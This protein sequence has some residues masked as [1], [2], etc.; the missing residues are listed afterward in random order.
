MLRQCQTCLQLPERLLEK[1][2]NDHKS[3]YPLTLDN[4]LRVVVVHNPLTDRSAAAIAVNVGHFNDPKDRQGLAHFLEHMLFLGTEKYPDGSEYN[5]FISQHGGNNNA[6]TGTEHTSFFFDIDSQQFEPALDRFSSFFICPLLSKEFV[7]SERQNIDAEFKLKLKDDI[8]R[9]YDVHKETINQKHPFSQFSVGNI[10]T[11]EDRDNS[12]IRDEVAAF[13]ENYYRAQHMTLVL[14]GPQ[15]IEQ[16]TE[17]AKQYFGAIKS[18]TKTLPKITEPLY[19]ADNLGIQIDVK[20]EKQ[21][22]NLIISFAMPALDPHYRSKPLS[23]ISYLL[24]HEGHGS[25]LSELKRKQWAMSLTAGGGINASNFKDFNISLQLTESGLKHQHDIVSLVFSYINL[26]KSEGFNEVYYKE[27]QTLYSHAFT[28]Q[29]KLSSID[30]AKQLVLNMQHYPVH[31]YIFGDYVMAG[32]DQALYNHFMAYLDATNMRLISIHKDIVPSKVSHWYQV[33]YHVEK[34]DDNQLSAWQQSPLLD[35]FALPPV[36][37]Y[38]ISDPQVL[39]LEPQP[40]KPQVIVDNSGFRVWHRQDTSFGVPKGNI[41]I[42][43]DSPESVSSLKNMAMTKLFV[44][45]FSDSVIEENYNAEIAGI[46]YHMF[47][48][49]AGFSLQISGFSQKQPDLLLSLSHGLHRHQFD[50]PRFELFR[51]QLVQHLKNSSKSKSI[52]QLFSWLSSLMQ[53]N[54]PLTA[55]VIDALEAIDFET[56]CR[57]CEQVFSSIAI[58]VFIYGNWPKSHALK[59]A[60]VIEKTF[61]GRLSEDAWVNCPVTDFSNKQQCLNTQVLPDHDYAALVYYPLENRSIELSVLAMVT[62]HLMSPLFFQAMR[63]EKQFGYLVGVGYIPINQFPGLGLYIQSPNFD[64]KVLTDEIFAFVDNFTGYLAQLPKQEW[65]YIKQGLIGQLLEKENSLR[66]KGQKYWLC[67]SNKDW[68]FNQK[69]K[70]IQAIDNLELEQVA[71]FIHSVLST[72]SDP[73]RIVLSSVKSQDQAD[74][75]SEDYNQMQRIKS[76]HDFIDSCNKKYPY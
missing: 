32:C 21:A 25:L 34:L 54:N 47:P 17:Y 66:I 59:I 7:V 74:S 76:Q 2:P 10:D 31:D 41:Y 53:P 28:F 57:F 9:L 36:N 75:L 63:T 50:Q 37:P 49:Q 68:E 6:W 62:S 27:K 73:D 65:Q 56:F 1:S 4:G 29:E 67:I 40:D 46:Q 26:L 20:P 16:L 39:P 12:C 70:L 19:L 15:A 5:Q 33:P 52:S 51:N 30:S 48:H 71:E 55:Q 60:S 8:R 23:Y 43:I 42:N 72:Q 14:E 35:C 58:E 64:A 38:L 3:Y 13:F 61:D 11:L 22:R 44:D 18:A 45:L 24:G 69:D